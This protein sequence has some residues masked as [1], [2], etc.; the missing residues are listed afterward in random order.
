[1]GNEVANIKNEKNDEKGAEWE[2]IEKN[3]QEWRC[4]GRVVTE[5]KDEDMGKR[6]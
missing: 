5:D 3:P 4:L 1:M 6:R 2:V